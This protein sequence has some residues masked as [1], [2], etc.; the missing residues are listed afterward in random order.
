MTGAWWAGCDVTRRRLGGECG[1]GWVVASAGDLLLL[2]L[3]LGGGA[4]VAGGRARLSY[5]CADAALRRLQIQHHIITTGLT[6]PYVTPI[7]M[8]PVVH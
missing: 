1:G 6:L 5:H 2:R 7:Y 3:G 4:A 8:Q